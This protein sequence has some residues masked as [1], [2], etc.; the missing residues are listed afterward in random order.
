MENLL[1][2]GVPILKHIRVDEKNKLS[3]VSDPD[4]EISTLGSMNNAGNSVSL[5]SGIIHLASGWDF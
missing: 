1:F 3:W 2:L 5:V 4:W